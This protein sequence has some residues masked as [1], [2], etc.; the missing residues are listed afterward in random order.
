VTAA[1]RFGENLYEA[2]TKSGMTQDQLSAR[3]TI[4]RTQIGELERG[5]RQPRL[6]T[7]VKLAGGLDVNPCALIQGIRWRPAPAESGEIEIL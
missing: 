5:I 4:H 2:R 6:E 7:I 1:K 3:S